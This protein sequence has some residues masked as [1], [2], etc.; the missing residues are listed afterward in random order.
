MDA[1]LVSLDVTAHYSIAPDDA[2]YVAKISDVYLYDAS[3]RTHLCELTPSYALTH[4]YTTID[5][6]PETPDELRDSLEQKYCYEPTDN[7]YMHCA[8]VER[9]ADKFH[10]GQ[11]EDMEEAFESAHST[12]YL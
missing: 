7:T 9:L 12:R 3:E 6:K 8:S 5:F 1:W 11:C 4:V 10:I 2:A